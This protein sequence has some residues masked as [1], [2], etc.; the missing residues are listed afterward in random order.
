MNKVIVPALAL[1]A[2][3]TLASCGG[4][5][6]PAATGNAT[7]LAFARAMV[8]HH[9]MAVEMARLAQ[10][11]GEHPEVKQLAMNVIRTQTSEIQ[12]LRPIEQQLAQEGVEGGS[13]GVPEH[14]TGMSGDMGM[15]SRAKPFDRQFIAMMVPHHEGAIRMA[16]VELDKG[17]EPRL[18]RLARQII[19]A[20]QRE[21][22]Q[23]RQWSERWY[24]SAPA[25]MPMAEGMRHG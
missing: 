23:M 15:L 20:Q 11:H 2:G 7:D 13:L 1:I 17:E 21:I 9:E 25:G 8:P 19:A 6:K 12:T 18:R 10:Q 16:R 14:M 5:E 4:D 3:V 22:A 24:G